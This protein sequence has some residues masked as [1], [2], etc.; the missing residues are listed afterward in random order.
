MD[1][2]QRAR[3]ESFQ[4]ANALI[5][6]GHQAV[7]RMLAEDTS[8]RL[9]EGYLLA[10]QF[11]ALLITTLGDMAEEAAK[12]RR[13]PSKQPGTQRDTVHAWGLD[14]VV[15]TD[16]TEGAYVRQ[17]RSTDLEEPERE[18]LRTAV[19]VYHRGADMGELFEQFGLWSELDEVLNQTEETY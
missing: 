1:D 12:A 13:L 5:E 8:G 14:L 18:Q 9:H 11:R 2:I 6:Q 15:D 4:R 3:L 10:N 19:A 17:P 16:T 7:R